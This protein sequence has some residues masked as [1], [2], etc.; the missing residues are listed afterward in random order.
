MG[1]ES[2]DFPKLREAVQI[3][4][5][6]E[7]LN[8]DKIRQKVQDFEVIHLESRQCH[9]VAPVA[10]D[11]GE[12]QISFDPV[13]IEILRVVDSNDNDSS[14][15]P[16]GTFES[17]SRNRKEGFRDIVLRTIGEDIRCKLYGNV[18]VNGNHEPDMIAVNMWNFLFKISE[19]IDP[20]SEIAEYYC[21]S[22]QGG[23]GTFARE[24]KVLEV[25][26]NENILA[27]RVSAKKRQPGRDKEFYL[28]KAEA[29][30]PLLVNKS[31][32]EEELHVS[33]INFE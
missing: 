9:S 31:P 25:L 19:N 4:V 20:E 3:A 18:M 22:F 17:E 28:L 8:V 5:K 30:K 14:R 12:N 32:S 6:A 11:G 33:V 16:V 24:E 1:L 7:A 15:S 13:H 10:M 29:C 23:G 2:V 26:E 21:K 27:I